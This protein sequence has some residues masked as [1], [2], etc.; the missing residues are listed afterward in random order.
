MSQRYLI[1]QLTYPFQ[2]GSLN[3]HQPGGSQSHTSGGLVITYPDS[4]QISRFWINIVKR[5]EG[6]VQLLNT[7]LHVLVL[8]LVHVCFSNCVSMSSYL[9]WK[10]AKVQFS[11][12][13][14]KQQTW[15]LTFYNLLIKKIMYPLIRFV[16]VCKLPFKD[17]LNQIL[18]RSTILLDSFACNVNKLKNLIA[19]YNSQVL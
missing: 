11:F 5:L 4:H 8:Q 3:S 1:K 9:Q 19:L 13:I 12:Q 18:S 2:Y 15:K 6:L 7:R 14:T 17:I 16:I 10:Q